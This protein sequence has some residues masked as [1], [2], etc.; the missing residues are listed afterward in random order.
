M[1]RSGAEGFHPPVEEYLKTIYELEEE[2][3]PVIRARIAERLGH[4]PPTVTE[5]VARLVEEGYLRTD[6]RKLHMTDQGH[7]HAESVVRRHRLAE[8]L[9]IDIIGI[10]WRR[11]HKEADRWEH[12]ISDEV[13]P[14][15]VALLGNPQT[16]PHGNP[17]P[18]SG[19]PELE[20]RP[21]SLARAGDSIRLR[22]ISEC[23]ELDFDML[24]YLDEHDFR[25][26][27]V[28]RVNHRAPDGT[29]TLDV[30][31]DIISLGEELAQHL[32]VD[33]P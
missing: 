25:P 2:G 30:A 11:A 20:T 17:I 16:C 1:A 10:E 33:R 28:A 5:M 24:S 19:A 6:K 26:G 4:S 32:Y 18:G 27:A 8:R 9:L 29:L 3:V 21:L 13:E 22:R 12:V 14:R 23:V 7:R 31:G 15:L